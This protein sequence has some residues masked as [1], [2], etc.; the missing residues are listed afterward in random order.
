M[1]TVDTVVGL[2]QFARR[3]AGTDA[4][5]RAA[6]WLRDELAA[7]GRDARL[8]PFWC[9]P[10]WAL[11]AAWHVALALAGSL[12]SVSSPRVGGALL[13]AALLSA[14]A[15]ATTGRSLGRRLTPERASQNVVSQAPADEGRVRL[16][17]TANYDAGRIGLAY[18]PELR[19]LVSRLNA[20]I[21]HAGPGWAGWLTI[22]MV[23]L[24]AVAV[25][26]LEGSKGTLIGV[27]QL[28]P[29]V[30]LVLGLALLLELAGAEYGPAAGDDGTGVAAAIALAGALAAGPPANA[31]VE[32]VLQGASDG[33][34]AGLRRHLGGRRMALRAANTVVLGIAAAGGGTPRWWLSDGAF[35]PQRYFGQLRKLCAQ[36]AEEEPYLGAEPHRSRGSAPSFPARAARLPAIAIGAV[37]GDT[38]LVPRSHQGSDTADTVDAKALNATVQFGLMLIDAIDAYLASVHAR[39]ATQV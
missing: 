18:R 34:G 17:I 12:V 3:G 4:E 23:W 29:T 22:A 38:G 39:A 7:S 13:L 32:V 26:R 25:A 30:G 5:R 6:N 19:R 28:L 10:N 35:V 9:R 2:A 21:G 1:R 16:V 37:D 20:A 33:D 11:A 36:V 24:L 8:E 27:L 31:A 14:V 15:D